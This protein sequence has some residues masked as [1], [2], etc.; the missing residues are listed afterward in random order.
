MAHAAGSRA[1][2]VIMDP[3]QL[4]RLLDL[5]AKV[6]NTDD[7]FDLELRLGPFDEDDALAARALF[8]MASMRC[9]LSRGPAPSP[10]RF[11]LTRPPPAGARERFEVRGRMGTRIVRVGW[12]DGEWFGSLYAI[13]RLGSDAACVADATDAR[14]RVVALL[15]VVLDVIVDDGRSLAVA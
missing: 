4:E 9:H 6:H 8:Q 7:L 12:A 5:L 10:D 13:G 3:A 1:P 2:G 14:E 15:D 11:T